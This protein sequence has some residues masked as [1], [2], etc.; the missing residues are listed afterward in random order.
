MPERSSLLQGVQ[1]GVESVFGTAVVANKLLQSLG[2]M[3]K[4]ELEMQ[5]FRSSGNKVDTLVT[6]GKESASA[7]VTGR[8]TYDE[9]VYPL[10]SILTTSAAVTTTG[11]TGKQWV[12][13]PAV[14]AEDTPKSFTIEQGGAVRAHKV[15]GAILTDF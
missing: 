4:P 15:A 2:F 11:T 3:L 7:D 14:A 1:I 9:I 13:T 5:R 10:S 6:L 12:F 8:G